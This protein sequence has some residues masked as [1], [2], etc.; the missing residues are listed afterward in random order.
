MSESLRVGGEGGVGGGAHV[1]QF[2][3]SPYSLSHFGIFSLS[4][5]CADAQTDSTL[6]SVRRRVLRLLI[7]LFFPVQCKALCSTLGAL[8]HRG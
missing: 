7:C 4:E 6:V 2:Q 8:K 3:K 5:A 1:G